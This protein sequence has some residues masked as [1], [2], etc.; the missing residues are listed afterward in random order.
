MSDCNAKI[1]KES[2][3]KTIMGENSRH[4]ETNDNVKD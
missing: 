2:I 4:E 3:Y 1:G